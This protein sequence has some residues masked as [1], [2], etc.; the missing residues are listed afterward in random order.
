MSLLFRYF[1]PCYFGSE[2]Q[3]EYGNLS[4]DIFETNWLEG[5]KHQK[6]DFLIIQE[7]LKKNF[8]LE[9]GNILPVNLSTF[10]TIVKSVYSLYT[11]LMNL[12]N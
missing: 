7:F 4:K 3:N 10:L 5:N 8:R 2:I 1:I 12:N 6:Q 9:G 11:V